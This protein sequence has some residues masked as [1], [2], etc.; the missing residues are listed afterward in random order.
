MHSYGNEN[1]RQ[2]TTQ[3]DGHR[4][5]TCTCLSNFAHQWY[6]LIYIIE[7]DLELS[8]FVDCKQDILGDI[9]ELDGNPHIQL[10]Q[11][12]KDKLFV[13]PY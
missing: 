1:G 9:W 10:A 5:I 4:R 12:N 6:T 7:G 3:D 11:Y 8:E 13:V 2:A